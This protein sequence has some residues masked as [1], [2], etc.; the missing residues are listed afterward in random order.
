MRTVTIGLATLHLGDCREL[1]PTLAADAIVSDPP[2]GIAYKSGRSTGGKW[3]FVRHQGVKIAGDE[4]PFDPAPMVAL[5]LPMI[6]W[7]AN[8]YSDKLP[9]AGWLV[10]D[11]R[12]GIEDMK[13]NR[14][15]AELAL[16]T[17]SKTV[18]TFRHLWHGLCRDSEIG[19]HH[20]PTQKPVALMQWCIEQL[21]RPAVICDPYMGSGTT[22]VAA[23][24]MGLR[25]I[26]CEIDPHYFEV[27]MQ[28]IEDAQ[29][30][31]QMFALPSNAQVQPPSAEGAKVGLQPLVGLSPMQC[32]LRQKHGTPAEFAAACYRAVPEF[33]SMDEA[34][35]AIR[36]YNA[37][38]HAARPSTP[39][40]YRAELHTAD[41][42]DE[43]C[44]GCF[45]AQRPG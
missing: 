36:N 20:H 45:D 10:W 25:F 17:Q 21:G 22:G 41:C 15:D 11:K 34:A 29:R 38:W 19:K 23:V 13:F 27:A 3:D 44:P 5:G 43:Q 1:L 8:F 30:Q 24:T 6:L 39:D 31:A 9:G 35:T 40:D 26:G 7:G 14:S 28:R 33:I 12:P 42:S 16:N 4:L 37:E 2:Y 32:E 18:K